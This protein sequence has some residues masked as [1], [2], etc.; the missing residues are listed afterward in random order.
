MDRQVATV[1]DDSSPLWR[2]A[3]PGRPLTGL[4][5]LVVEDS[6]FASEAVRLL[7]LRSG[8]RI[9]R[10]DC[11][12]TAARHLQM[13]R[14]AVVIVDLGLP[15]GNGA[16]LIAQ[17]A[18]MSPRVPVVLGMSG[19]PDN[20]SVAL[21][22]GA[23]GFMPKPIESLA[24]F[25]HAILSVLPPEAR[26]TGLRVVSD[27]M[28]APDQGALRDDLAHVAEVLASSADT[29]AIDYIAR[30]LAGV[31]RSARD[32]PLEQAAAALARD[33]SAGRALAADLA[34]ISGM[35]Q[36]RLSAANGA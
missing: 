7:C 23:D 5:V 6:R 19:D 4:T 3:P 17:M 27:E 34:R 13:Y 24:L 25:Q 16:Q 26:P 28:V 15:D 20:E 10:A 1:H 21:A 33:H 22:A 8:A 2:G 30:F 31:A 29:G 12:R 36:D 18:A 32:E 9:R 11:L 35:V 14:P